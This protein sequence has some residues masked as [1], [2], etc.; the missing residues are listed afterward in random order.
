M[1]TTAKKVAAIAPAP[2]KAK[3]GQIVTPDAIPGYAE[4][5][6]LDVCIKE[7][8]A[9]K[10][11]KKGPIDRTVLDRLI[12]RGLNTKTKP[13]TMYP[14]DGKAGGSASLTRRG[15]NARLQTARL[16]R[17]R[18]CLASSRTNPEGWRSRGSPRRGKSKF[19][20]SQ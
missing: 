8:A 10:E 14:A 15:S 3:A 16:R 20:F 11:L 6:A 13:A 7:L 5:A 18:S 12:N 17:S 1:F 19:R 9:L 2:A 4:V